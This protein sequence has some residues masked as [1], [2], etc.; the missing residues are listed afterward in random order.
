MSGKS[1]GRRVHLVCNAHLDPMWLWHWEDGCAAALATLRVAADFC[2]EFP[3][4]VFTQNEAVL[5]H[6]TAELDPA[7]HERISGLVAARRWHVAGGAWLQPDLNAPGG[8]SHIRQFLYGKQYFERHFSRRPTTAYNFDSFGH[9]EGF[10]QVLQGCGMDSYLFSRP[11]FGTF[12]L[13]VGVFAWR[14]RSGSEI[15]ARRLDE[16]YRSFGD[17]DQRLT[18]WLDHYCHEREPLLVWGIGNHGGG[19]SREELGQLQRWSD[20]HPEYEL[21]HS[22]P[23]AFFAAAR[24]DRQAKDVVRGEIQNSFPGCYSSMARLKRMHR[25]TAGEIQATERLATLAWWSRGMSFPAE[26]LDKAWQDLLFSEFHDALAGSSTPDVERDTLQSLAHARE[27]CRHQRLRTLIACQHA[28]AAAAPGQTPVYVVNPHGFPLK[29]QVEIELNPSDRFPIEHKMQLEVTSAGRRIAHQALK[30]AHNIGLARCRLAV[31]LRLGPWEIRRLDV[32]LTGAEGVRSPA[33]AVD[34]AGPLHINTR[35]WHITINTRTG[36]I[37][38]LTPRAGGE[39]LVRAGA[40]AVQAFADL[41]HS[42]TCG[43]PDQVTTPRVW[44]QAPGW[45]RPR[46]QFR[47]ANRAQVAA[48]SPDP[49]DRWQPGKHTH[50]RALRII[51]DGPLRLTVE[52]IF[53]LGDSNVI[54]HYSFGKRDDLIRISDR[55]TFNAPDTLLKLAIPL[56]FQAR[57]CTAEACYSAARRAPSRLHEEHPGGRW[58][59]VQ[60]DADK[61]M[62]GVCS[63]G[64]FS[65]SF[66]ERELGLTLMRSPAY[67]SFGLKPDNPNHVSRFIERQEQGVHEIVTEILPGRIREHEL[68]MAAGALCMPPWWQTYFPNGR[69]DAQAPDPFTELVKVTP[70]A[71]EIVALKRSADGEALIV[72]VLNHAPRKVACR[73]TVSDRT[74]SLKLDAYRL[75][76]LR[77][78]RSNGRLRFR[79][80]SL[81]EELPEHTRG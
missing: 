52:A 20:E 50:A 42:W 73:L 63:T 4:F 8:E 57:N 54:R 61:Q 44:S 77:V 56:A 68:S 58:L 53:T 67:A 65:H 51:E 80:V 43:D 66:R 28:D 9:P 26:A 10:V 69:V 29:R 41:D 49:A 76:T 6:W 72:R 16:G 78:E 36:L 59:M 38:A 19:P 64:V 46:G 1:P 32:Q 47:L 33:A 18:Q 12:D 23:E 79:R 70:T 31:E 45:T 60:G 17:L 40:F 3:G 13:P 7:L 11:D 5:Y 27:I 14:D 55:I 35:R 22:T 74:F 30:P 75:A 81:V 37:D 62:L 71:V 25:Q 21:A 39:S 48:L 24:R 15:L 2:D 34:T